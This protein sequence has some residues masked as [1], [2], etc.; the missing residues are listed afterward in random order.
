MGLMTRAVPLPTQGPFWT[1]FF[2]AIGAGLQA[3]TTPESTFHVTVVH[4]LVLQGMPCLK[5][6]V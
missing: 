3:C 2:P 4:G 1:G 6:T 5:A